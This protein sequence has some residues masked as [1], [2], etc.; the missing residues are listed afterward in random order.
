MKR[1]T[2]K[3]SLLMM[4]GIALATI[5]VASCSKSSST[6]PVTLIG[7]YASSDSVAAGNL[8]AYF[9][10]DGNSNDVKGNQTATTVGVTYPATGV[11][12]NSYQGG[13]GAYSTLTPNAALSSLGS[14][15]LS[16]WY[17]MAA[18][19]PSGD[20]GGIFFLSGTL[21]PNLLITEIES[22]APLS[23]DSVKIHHG[24]DD[25]ISPA[26]QGF[27]MES[28]D[29]M[30]IGKWIHQVTT[31]DGGSSTYTIYENG[32]PIGNNSAFGSNI[33]PTPMWTDGTKTTPLGALGWG[34][35]AP[36]Q[37][38]IGTWPAGLY[39]V[40]ATL[41]ANGCFNGQLDELRVFN[42]ALSTSEVA[43]LYL[44]GRAGR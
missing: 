19:Q 20:P 28:Y 41:G 38:V 44:N 16:F 23:G 3:L 12:G 26:Y 17:K 35:D 40:S 29:T 25:V 5:F 32:T 1:I 39:G 14:Y 42:K 11:R 2:S 18:Q 31:Y 7:G 13:V 10:F 24:F 27:T 37:I 36:V 15:S 6:P 33:T 9:P 34:T 8:V 22:Y 21:N 30:A 4:A 43:G